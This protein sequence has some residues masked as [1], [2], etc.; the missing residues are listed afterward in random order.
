MTLQPLDSVRPSTYNP[1][2]ADTDRLDL[3]ELSLRKLGFLLPVYATPSG[4]ILSGHQRHLVAVRMGCSQIPVET[5][6]DMDLATRK[7]INVVFNRATNDMAAG[8]TP[9]GLTADLAARNVRDLAATLPD[10]QPDTDAFFPCLHAADV[11]VPELC[12]VNSGRW[13]THACNVARTLG[14]RRIYMPIVCRRDGRVVNGI[15]R[16]E[17]AAEESAPTVPVVYV[18]DAEAV[19][20]EAMLN[21]LTMSFDI[22]TRY[23]DALRYNSFRRP[24]QR[25]ASLGRGFVFDLLGSNTPGNRLDL[26]LASDRERWTHHYGRVICD[27]G[28][29][30]MDETRMLVAAGVDVTPFEPY[31]LGEGLEIDPFEARKTTRAFLDRLATGVRF[32]SVFCSSVMNSVPFVG[33]RR[34]IVCILN[35]LCHTTTRVY[36]CAQAANSIGW[37]QA[38][39]ADPVDRDNGSSIRFRLDYE[40]RITLG[41]FSGMPKVQ[42]YHLPREWYD[43]WAERFAAVKVTTAQNNVECVCTRARPVDSQALE[44]ALAFEFDLPYPDGSRMGLVAYARDAFAARLDK[45]GRACTP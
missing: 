13:V 29:G 27:F 44:A 11:P 16:L 9:E 4:E 41:E 37:R 30:L 32:D 45:L 14:A 23:A 6:Q 5:I 12:R 28:A 20:A 1:R 24:R 31:M 22:H 26:T 2:Q 10:L 7:A 8:D 39:G 19:F 38:V 35:A 33:D 18:S 15:G 36:A 21:C 34:H 40:P 3:V 17:Y 25:R 43:L 42:K